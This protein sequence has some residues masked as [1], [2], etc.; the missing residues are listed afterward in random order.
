MLISIGVRKQIQS[1]YRF[2]CMTQCVS[3]N[4]HI[5]QHCARGHKWS[6][7]ISH[8]TIHR[9]DNLRATHKLADRHEMRSWLAV[10]TKSNIRLFVLC[11]SSKC[12]AW[13]FE[14]VSNEYECRP[15]L[16]FRHRIYKLS[17]DTLGLDS[18]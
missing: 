17:F 15:A 18:C 2:S 3:R 7:T 4:N 1:Y 12:Q 9:R 8:A 16:F 11:I 6:V 14:L 5:I 13:T 10:Y